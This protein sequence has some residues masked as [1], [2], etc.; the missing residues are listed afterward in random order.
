MGKHSDGRVNV[1]VTV[2]ISYEECF[3]WVPY[4]KLKERE[5]GMHELSRALITLCRI[6]AYLTSQRKRE[7]SP[8]LFQRAS[9]QMCLKHTN[10]SGDIWDELG[11]ASPKD[12]K[13]HISSWRWSAQEHGHAVLECVTLH[14]STLTTLAFYSTGDMVSWGG[15]QLGCSS[16][17]HSSRQSF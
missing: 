2:G 4:K 1:Q 12:R 3:F 9:T 10:E 14:I 8:G 15:C 16:T 5:V 17:I 6:V 7:I 13:F 11:K